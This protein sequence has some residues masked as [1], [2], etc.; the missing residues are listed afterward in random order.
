MK[1]II[2]ALICVIFLCACSSGKTPIKAVNRNISYRAHIFYYG[3][4]YDCDVI[5]D[6]DGRASYTLKNGTLDG[7]T[8]SYFNG[9][10]TLSYMEKECPQPYTYPAGGMLS[11]L[12]EMNEYL[13]SSYEIKEID[14]Q[15]LIQGYTS[16]GEFVISLS[17]AGLPLSAQLDSDAFYVEFYDVTLFKQ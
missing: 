12:Y 8:A 5:I 4:E 2:C 3:S 13:N 6:K 7:F 10:V 14:E 9:S 16:I 11:A 17:G 15:Y 1:K